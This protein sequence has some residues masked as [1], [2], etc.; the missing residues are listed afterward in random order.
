[1]SRQKQNSVDPQEFR[2]ET[3]QV[4][5]ITVTL[6]HPDLTEDERKRVEEDIRQAICNL[7]DD[8]SREKEQ[9]AEMQSA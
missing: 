5:N 3:I 4:G 2:V 9:A 8:A 7:M 1:M 6:R